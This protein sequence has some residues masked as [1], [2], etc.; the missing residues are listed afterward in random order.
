[1][2]DELAQLHTDWL[3]QCHYLENAL[4]I[5]R[6][7]VQ[8]MGE[9]ADCIRRMERNQE[10]AE[11]MAVFNAT[12]PDGAISGKNEDA[13]RAQ[14]TAFLAVERRSGSLAK[15]AADLEDA[16]QVQAK[17][18]LAHQEDLDTIKVAEYR[19][20]HLDAVIRALSC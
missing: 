13:R 20:K 19:M 16:K 3:K 14:R 10:D 17:N 18:E 4:K 7:R 2:N 5:A 12:K 9:T 11:A 6:E 1:M 8:L 15:Y